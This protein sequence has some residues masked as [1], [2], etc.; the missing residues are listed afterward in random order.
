M[1]RTVPQGIDADYYT[2][3]GLRRGATDIQIKAKFRQLALLRHPDKNPDNPNATLEFQ[4]V[5][6]FASSRRGSPVIVAREQ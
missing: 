2:V 4:L 6:I 3:L 1:S 5:S